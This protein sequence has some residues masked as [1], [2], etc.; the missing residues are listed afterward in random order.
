MIKIISKKQENILKYLTEY[1]GLGFNKIQALF[2]KRVKLMGKKQTATLL[3]IW[4]IWLKF[5]AK[6]IIFLT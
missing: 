4:A 2:R 3:L 5:F 1:E 6:I